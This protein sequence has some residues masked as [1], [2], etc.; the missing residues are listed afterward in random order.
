M[1]ILHLVRALGR[2]IETLALTVQPSTVDQVICAAVAERQR[3]QEIRDEFDDLY[4][5]YPLPTRVAGD[6]SH[7]DRAWV[8]A[9]DD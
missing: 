4:A 8:L 6:L 3:T 2:P 1:T 5:A 7:D 9:V